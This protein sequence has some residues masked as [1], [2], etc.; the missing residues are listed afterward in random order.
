MS[1]NDVIS[2]HNLPSFGVDISAK[3]LE[4]LKP[5]CGLNRSM[6]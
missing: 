3:M 4:T 5:D 1:P 2:M 6:P